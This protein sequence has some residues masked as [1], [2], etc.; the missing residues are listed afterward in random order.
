M[1]FGHRSLKVVLG[2]WRK[3]V[4]SV[5]EGWSELDFS[6]DGGLGESR[7]I[8]DLFVQNDVSIGGRHSDTAII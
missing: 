8:G 4:W 5:E 7:Q 1:S 6:S 2:G 3:D